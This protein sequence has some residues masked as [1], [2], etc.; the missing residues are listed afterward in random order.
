MD[1]RQFL[2]AAAATSM[3]AGRALAASSGPAMQ[4]MWLVVDNHAALAGETA[5]AARR[6]GARVSSV[7]QDLGGLMI[8]LEAWLERPSNRIVGLTRNTTFALVQSFLIPHRG[9]LAFKMA[10]AAG[11]RP[12]PGTLTGDALV[13]VGAH[14]D[15][16]RGTGI[17][18]RGIAPTRSSRSQHL[19]WA[20]AAHD[21]EMPRGGLVS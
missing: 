13:R 21:T 17:A 1:R 4:H 10:C 7:P 15:I 6:A 20:I 11:D 16:R 19:F 2:M 8:D 5:V 12:A 18:G 14:L 9:R 3:M